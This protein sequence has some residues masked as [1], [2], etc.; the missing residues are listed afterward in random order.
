MEVSG[1]SHGLYPRGKSPHC[2]LDRGLHVFKNQVEH[3]SEE[4]YPFSCCESKFGRPLRNL[5]TNCPSSS[6]HLTLTSISRKHGLVLE[7]R[8]HGRL[9]THF[10]YIISYCFI[11]LKPSFVLT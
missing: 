1:Q 7:K 10:R 11:I 2:P 5:V 6:F 9:A 8:G 3:G 4:K